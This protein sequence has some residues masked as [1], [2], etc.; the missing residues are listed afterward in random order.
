[1]GHS[2]HLRLGAGQLECGTHSWSHP[3]SAL[4]LSRKSTW[5]GVAQ[6]RDEGGRFGDASP[7]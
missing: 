1:M 2:P 3:P 4:A 7:C 5:K 6:R